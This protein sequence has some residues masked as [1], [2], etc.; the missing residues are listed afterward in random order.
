MLVTGRGSDSPPRSNGRLSNVDKGDLLRR[1]VDTVF[2]RVST[3][4]S[5]APSFLQGK[6]VTLAGDLLIPAE[7]SNAVGGRKLNSKMEGRNNGVE[8][9]DSRSANNGIVGR[10]S[11]DNQKIQIY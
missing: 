7:G 1:F 6:S 3:R 9:G 10:G 2:A 5:F 4:R 11:F 8:A